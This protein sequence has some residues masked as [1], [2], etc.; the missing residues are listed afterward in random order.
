[1]LVH[2]RAARVQG[3][4]NGCRSERRSSSAL[5]SS[6]RSAAH[7]RAARRCRSGPPDQGPGACGGVHITVA[8][9]F[10]LSTAPDARTACPQAAATNLQQ[11]RPAPRVARSSYIQKQQPARG[12]DKAALRGERRHQR[13]T[14]WAELESKPPGPAAAGGRRRPGTGDHGEP[15]VVHVDL[16]VD[17]WHARRCSGQGQLRRAACC[18]C[19]RC[20]S[21]AHRRRRAVPPGTAALRLYR[22]SSSENVTLPDLGCAQHS[23]RVQQRRAA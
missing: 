11:T 14:Q 22:A 3:G 23:G 5:L 21:A 9:K 13:C 18:C 2:Q 15:D 4:S 12:H 8:A 20:R 19:S 7:E 17:K 6:M 1:M 10:S 16:E